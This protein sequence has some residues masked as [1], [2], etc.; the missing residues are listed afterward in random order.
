MFVSTS[1]SLLVFN[2]DCLSSYRSRRSRNNATAVSNVMVGTFGK[3]TRWRFPQVV[4]SL[5]LAVPS[6]CCRDNFLE[7]TL[8]VR[9]LPS[10]L[11]LYS[12]ECSMSLLDDVWLA[13][14]RGVHFK[15]ASVGI[16]VPVA[17]GIHSTS[18]TLRISSV[19][20]QHEP[21]WP[22]LGPQQRLK[23]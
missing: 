13:L 8:V 14:S 5:L 19:V 7:S 21:S 1:P 9:Y 22:I 20:A 4:A 3:L 12:V 10:L 18:D 15:I 11:L 23:T 6:R 16:F 17:V 2:T